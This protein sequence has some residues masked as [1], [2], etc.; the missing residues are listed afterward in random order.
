MSSRPI[1][2][3]LARRIAQ[4]SQKDL[5]RKAGVDPALISRLE[6]GH[7][8]RRPSYEAIIRIARVL[9]V[10]PTDLFPVDEPRDAA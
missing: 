6:T 2:L 4:L 8:A 7:R 1:S 9:N 10:D 3:K 5:A